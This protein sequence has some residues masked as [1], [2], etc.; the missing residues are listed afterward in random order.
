MALSIKLGYL[1]YMSEQVLKDGYGRTINYLRLAVT[2]R[3]NLRCFYC[4]P[5]EG[6]NYVR[7]S[8]LLT[9]E[10]MVRLV[11]L[12][13]ELGVEKLRITGGEPFLRKDIMD[14]L[15][16]MSK[17][18]LKE[19][20]MTTNGTLTYQ[21]IPVLK[22]LGVQSVNLSLDSLDSQR[23]F[24]ITRRDSFQTVMKTFHRLMEFE[25][26]TKINMVVMAGRNTEDIIPMA[27]LAE[28]YP[29]SVRFIEEMPFNG[30]GDTP[31]EPWDHVMIR[32]R[33]EQHFPSLR[34]I[35]TKPG[36][37]ASHLHVDGFEGNLGIIAAYS[38]TFCGTCNRLRVT[39][40][41]VLRT[42]LYDEGVF[43]IR[44]IMRQGAT[45]T[46]LADLIIDAV[47]HKAKDGFEAESQRSRLSE[48]MSTIGG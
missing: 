43:N 6:I 45:D 29:V 21:H 5:E 22:S 1:Y 38:R 37:T 34:K 47:A 41:G 39:P 12:L 3:C 33:L 7:R 27:G 32:N 48:S 40:K 25:I 8:E 28:K 30:T 26:P 17:S 4:M 31:V 42:C 20:H 9:Y 24:Q 46:Q 19:I 36:A 23:F 2:D 35:P 14:F 44:E 16:M 18:A 10:E 15:R 13:C 11:H